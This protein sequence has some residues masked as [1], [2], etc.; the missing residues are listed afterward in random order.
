MAF[1][2]GKARCVIIKTEDNF[3]EVSIMSLK[4]L[5]GM[6]VMVVLTIL[7]SA[8]NI[9][10][11]PAPTQDVGLIYTQ[12]AQLVA[13]QFAM[14]QTQT[15]LAVPPT[16]LPSPTM[17]AAPVIP[18]FPVATPFGVSTP[19]GGATPF[20]ASTPFGAATQPGGF[21][22]TAT[23]KALATAA[24]PQCDSAILIAD[25]TVP[26]GTELK[27]GKDFEKVWRIQNTGTCTWD[28]GYSFVYMGGSLDGYNLYFKTEEKF[29]KPGATV[30]LGVDLTASL[31][32]NTYQEC[33]SMMNDK[34]QYFPYSPVACV[35]I[36][37]KK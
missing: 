13:T 4:K 27:P 33:W 22:P 16:P 36:V 35:K 24:A 37:V 19:F 23:I 14:Q 9:G 2:S 34:G 30:D 15:A 31:T 7:L 5:I 3:M 17:A 12:A 32:P 18:T 29:V 10:A 28:D 21:L 26:D 1:T 25:I 20:G 8:C 11:T 6:A